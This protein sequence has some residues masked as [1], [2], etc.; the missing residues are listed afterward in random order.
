MS[1]LFALPKENFPTS[2]ELTWLYTVTKN[3]TLQFMRKERLHI[4]L[5]DVLDIAS[6]TDDFSH[7]IDIDKYRD[8]IKTL[9][10]ISKAIVTLKVISGFSHKEIGSTPKVVDMV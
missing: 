6:G 10:E 3:E 1:K 5:D 9:D 2:H 4:P 7:I 8:M